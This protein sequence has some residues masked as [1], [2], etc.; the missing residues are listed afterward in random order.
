MS[1]TSHGRPVGAGVD[2]PPAAPI[3]PDEPVDPVE[4]AEPERGVSPPA[5][6]ELRGSPVES[7]TEPEQPARKISMHPNVL[8]FRSL[9]MGKR[10]VSARLEN[11]SENSSFLPAGIFGSGRT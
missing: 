1:R 2:D 8:S 3:E 7:P 4:P 6:D 11:Q 9:I 10:K 5:L